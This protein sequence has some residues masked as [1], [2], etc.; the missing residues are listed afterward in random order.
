MSRKQKTYVAIQ[1]YDDKVIA[2][3]T[4]LK[5]LKELVKE[6]RLM[7]SAPESTNIVLFESILTM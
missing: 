3:S 6:A 4:S 7:Q 5:D 2:I 1:K